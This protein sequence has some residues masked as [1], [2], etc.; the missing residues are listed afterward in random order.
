M[1]SRNYLLYQSFLSIEGRL[2]VP[3]TEL[4]ME[5]PLWYFTHYR[6]TGILLS[7]CTTVCM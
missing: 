6:G 4:C 5:Q 1:E 3:G 2:L 7:M